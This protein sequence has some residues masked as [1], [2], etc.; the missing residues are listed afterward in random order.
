MLPLF[1]LPFPF[2]PLPLRLLFP[3]PLLTAPVSIGAA[4]PLK[5]VA[6]LDDALVDAGRLLKLYREREDQRLREALQE[7][8]ES[9]DPIPAEAFI[10]GFY[11]RNPHLKV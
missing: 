8:L 3:V 7:G 9:G 1:P 5:F 6:T 11:A 4:P 2:F 10:E